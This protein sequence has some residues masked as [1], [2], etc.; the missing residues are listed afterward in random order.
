MAFSPENHIE[1][2]PTAAPI[3][4]G[5]QVIEVMFADPIALV[6]LKE[7]IKNTLDPQPQPLLKDPE[8]LSF[9]YL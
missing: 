2:Q 5:G 1:Y 6:G 7:A 3:E 4:A 9:D 8:K